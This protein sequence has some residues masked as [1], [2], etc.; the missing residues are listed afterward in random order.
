MIILINNSR[1][2]STYQDIPLDI[3]AEMSQTGFTVMGCPNDSSISFEP[4]KPSPLNQD[5]DNSLKRKIHIETGKLNRKMKEEIG[6]I[7]NNLTIKTTAEAVTKLETAK[8]QL[9]QANVDSVPWRFDDGNFRELTVADLDDLIIRVSQAVQ[10]NFL[11]EKN[12][13]LS[14]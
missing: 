11:D 13:V 2:H 14:L 5:I 4:G 8:R 6:I 3:L 1:I 7:W 9:E 10:K 12:E